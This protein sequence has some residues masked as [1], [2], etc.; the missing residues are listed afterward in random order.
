MLGKRI[1]YYE[2]GSK[3]LEYN[4]LSE[5]DKGSDSMVFAGF[6]TRLLTHNLC[7]IDKVNVTK[8]FSLKG[9]TK[10]SEAR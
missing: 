2:K 5:I 4:S 1:Y 8:T 9:T 3:C 10:V 7:D 6:V